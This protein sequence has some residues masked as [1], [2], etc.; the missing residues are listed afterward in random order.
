MFE[1]PEE[2]RAEIVRIV[3]AG[4]Y[5]MGRNMFGPGRGGH[6]VHVTLCLPD[7]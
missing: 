3:N 6:V 2:N 4:S 7:R 1:H 5:I